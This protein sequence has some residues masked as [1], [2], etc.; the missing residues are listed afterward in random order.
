MYILLLFIYLWKK[1]NIRLLYISSRGNVIIIFINT[2]LPI[3]VVWQKLNL[4]I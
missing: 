2:K 1:N 3:K 4:K